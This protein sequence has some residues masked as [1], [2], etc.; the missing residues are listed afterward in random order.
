MPLRSEEK[1]AVITSIMQNTQ[2]R[3]EEK[4][5][6]VMQLIASE[7]KPCADTEQAT[8]HEGDA[9]SPKE[10]VAL[11]TSNLQETLNPEILEDVLFKQQRPLIIYWGMKACIDTASTL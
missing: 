11:I 10:K 9:L 1:L 5:T 4:N 6:Q 8:S 7:P 3:L 2:L